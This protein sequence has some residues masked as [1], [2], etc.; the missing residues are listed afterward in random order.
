MKNSVKESKEAVESGYWQLYRY[1]P[2]QS[3]K[4]KE[5]L[6][7]DFKKADF[8][9]IPDLLNTQ[10]RFTALKKIKND[11]ELVGEMYDQTIKD[12]QQ[13]AGT[14]DRMAQMNKAKKK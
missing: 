14:Y 7:I 9:K 12:M 13:R 1:D 4:G 5:P 3:A 11:P 6:R 10:T 8:N 2:R